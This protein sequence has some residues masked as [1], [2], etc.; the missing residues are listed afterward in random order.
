NH[1]S[2]VRKVH[3]HAIVKD[4]KRAFPQT[5]VTERFTITHNAPIYL[6]ELLESTICH[7]NRQRF[8][9][10]STGAIRN[11]RLVFEMVVFSGFQFSYE[12]TGR[13]GIRYHGIF[14]FTDLSFKSIATIKKRHRVT[15]CFTL[16]YQFIDFLRAQ[17]LCGTQHLIAVLH[18]NFIGTVKSN[19]FWLHFDTESWEIGV[20]SL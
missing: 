6:V 16:S 19:E 1:L 18:L 15:L 2:I 7:Q 17:M 10:Y 12:I 8:T 5:V 11:D 3:A 13:G 20:R 14:K 9:T 4:I